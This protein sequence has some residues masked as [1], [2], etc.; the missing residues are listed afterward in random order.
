[1]QVQIMECDHHYCVRLVPDT[2]DEAALL[3]RMRWNMTTHTSH[4]I[5]CHPGQPMDLRMFQQR[6]KEQREFQ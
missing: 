3:V 2:A 4:Q 6:R 5:I 1:M